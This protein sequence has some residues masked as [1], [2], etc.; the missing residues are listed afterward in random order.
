[1]LADIGLWTGTCPIFIKLLMEVILLVGDVGAGQHDSIPTV[2]VPDICC[3]LDKLDNFGLA[4]GTGSVHV[5]L[6]STGSDK[7]DVRM[8]DSEC[9]PLCWI[10]GNIGGKD[11][12]I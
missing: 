6:V 4:K 12:E 1:M 8:W 2:G 9:R 5:L 11:P 10:R 7:G 3:P